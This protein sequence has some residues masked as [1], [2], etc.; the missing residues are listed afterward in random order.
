M[1][2]EV[3]PD[4][5]GFNENLKTRVKEAGLTER[6]RFFGELPIDDVPAW[7]RRILIYAFTSRNECFGLTLLEAMASGAALTA[8]RRPARS[9]R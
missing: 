9:T 1:I 5:R 3:T 2:G 6:V 8:A 7:Y 4:Q